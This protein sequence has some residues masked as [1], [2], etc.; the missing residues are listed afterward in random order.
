MPL[1]PR[2]LLRYSLFLFVGYVALFLLRHAPEPREVPGILALAPP[3]YLAA[4]EH[5]NPL[6]QLNLWLGIA[7]P[8]SY[9]VELLAIFALLFAVYVAALRSARR[10][11]ASHQALT[12]VLAGVVVFSLP[13]IL[14]PYLLS[15]DVYSYIIYG[16][17]AALYGANPT[18]NAPLAFAHD[19]YFQFLISWKDTPSVYGPVWTLLSHMLTLAVEGLGGG[20]WLY[21][22]AYKLLMVAAHLLGSVLIWLT[23]GRWNPERQLY[24]TLLYGW[25]PVLLIEF[26]LSSHNDVLMVALILLALFYAQRGAWRAAIVA[27]VA[28]ALVKWAALV[29]LPLLVLCWLRQQPTWRGRLAIAGQAAAIAAAVVVLLHLPYGGGLRALAAPVT[30]QTVMKAENSIGA[31]SVRIP[32]EALERLGADPPRARAARST[33][34]AMLGWVSKG[35]VVL[36][37]LAAMLAVWRRPTFARLLAAGFWLLVVVLLVSPVFRVWYVAWPLALAALLPWRPYGRLTVVFAACAPLLYLDGVAPAWMEALVFLPVIA[38]LLYEVWRGWLRAWYEHGR[39][40]AD[41][42][43]AW[44][45]SDAR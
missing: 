8:V 44:R 20:A 31:L 43:L 39:T 5:F 22:L 18:L 6:H 4:A 42:L 33:A 37:W 13:L 25:N 15:R 35:L 11:K 16:R 34:E 30:T 19:P 14:A 24:G 36:A 26:V 38:L 10:G 32:Q 21:V 40:A 45:G 28:A 17:M 2:T 27:L 12:I 1:R 41:P 23:L 29:L 9:R 7:L 3:G